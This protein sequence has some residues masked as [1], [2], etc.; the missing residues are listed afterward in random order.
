MA[1]RH[2]HGDTQEEEV[3]LVRPLFATMGGHLLLC[4]VGV[5]SPVGWVPC[6]WG[7]QKEAV[8]LMAAL[9]LT[10]DG[11]EFA[12]WI[13]GAGDYSKYLQS[14][15]R[16]WEGEAGPIPFLSCEA[17]P[18]TP[19]E[20]CQ[21]FLAVLTML[22]TQRAECQQSVHNRKFTILIMFKGTVQWH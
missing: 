17:G 8:S 1:T 13:S 16:A 12:C 7:Y 19:N 22:R 5:P 6:P 18:C 10:Q 15:Q 2:F 4:E 21:K 3:P 11:A 14:L 20:G 9:H